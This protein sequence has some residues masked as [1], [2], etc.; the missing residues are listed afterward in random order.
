MQNTGRTHFKRT[1]IDNFLNKLVLYIGIA[2]ILLAVISAVGHVIFESLWG[3]E[4]QTYLPWPD[5]VSKE[6]VA[7]SEFVSGC[8]MFWSYIILLN[9]LVPISLYVSVEIIRL[10]QS[11]FINWD[12]QMYYSP[13]DT[14]ALARTTTLNEELGQVQYIFSDK[15]GTLTQNIMTF[16]KCSINGRSFG[17]ILDEVTGEPI[18]L[19]EHSKKVD[20]SANHFFEPTF[21]FY[22]KNLLTEVKSGNPDTHSF[23]RLLALCHTVMPQYNDEGNLEYQAQSPDENALVSAA[24]N[25]GFVFTER[26]SRTITIQALGMVETH[27][28]LCILDFNNVRKRMSVIVKYEGKI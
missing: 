9:T 18:D 15:T 6:K 11:F 5:T 2:L 21:E 19:D 24:R 3:K 7:P 26:S 4:F 12:R 25:F 28:L 16:N 20:F 27:E 14:P 8:L 22:D 23:F 10:G 13:K 17:D 1:S